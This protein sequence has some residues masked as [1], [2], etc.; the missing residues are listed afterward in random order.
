[1]YT[2]PHREAQNGNSGSQVTERKRDIHD[3][4]QAIKQR[5]LRY[6]LTSF[7]RRF[8]YGLIRLPGGQEYDPIFPIARYSPWNLDADFLKTYSVI[9]RNTLVDIYRCWELWTLLEQAAKLPDGAILEVGVWRG[10]TGALLARKA[11]LLGLQAPTYL[12]DTFTGV[13]KAADRDTVYKGGE[14][15][16]T[17]VEHVQSLLQ[18]FGASQ[19]KILKGIFPDETASLIPAGTTFRLVHVDVD[20]YQSAKDV[21]IWSW[22]RVLPG[23]IVVFDDYGDIGTT[24]VK[25]L[26]NESIPRPDRLVIH[27]LNGHGILVKVG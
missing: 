4:L 12:C 20:V 14:H 19:A 9:R 24:G 27:N 23:G 17:S 21:L 22:S 13:V 18:S 7:L 6:V 15:A 2:E 8:G 16:D 25:Q 10:G 1:M 26:V 5:I 11:T 3:Q